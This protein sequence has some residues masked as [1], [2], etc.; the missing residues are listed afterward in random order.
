[1]PNIK[2]FAQDIEHVALNQIH[3]LASHPVFMNEKIRIMP[4]VHAGVGSVIGFTSTFTDKIIPYTIGV[5]IG[6][7]VIVANIGKTELNLSSVDRFIKENIPHGRN[8]HK[9]VKAFFDLSK[10]KIYDALTNKKHIEKSLGTLGGGNH[11]IE[12]GVDS[13]NDK[14]LMIHTGSRNLGTQVAEYYQK[15]AINNCLKKDMNLTKDLCYLSGNYCQD[16]LHDMNICLKYASLNRLTILT[17][18]LEKYNLKPINVFETIHNY[19]DIEEKIIRKGAVS[20]QR[21]ELLL[22]PL[23]MADGSIIG[24]GLGNID[25]NCSAPHGAGRVLSRTKAKETLKL[26]EFYEKMGNIYSTTVSKKTIDEAPMAYKNSDLILKQIKETVK[27]IDIIKPIYN[28]K[29]EH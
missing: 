7:G 16:Y 22:I 3:A 25:W 28:F 19:I 24:H 13:K 17:L 12:I 4:D 14:Y 23:N 21:N 20:A 11:F 29:S 1:M 2:I 9:E 6:C 18:I 27:I 26:D 5:D 15:L 10:L 8:E